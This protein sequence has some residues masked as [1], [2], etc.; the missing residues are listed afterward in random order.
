M[1]AISIGKNPPDEVN[2]VDRSGR[3]AASRS[4]TRWTRPPARSSS[5]ASSTRRCAIRELRLHPAY[6]VGR[7][8]SCATCSSPTPA[9]WCR[10]PIIAVRPIGVM[11]MEDEGGGD[12]KI[13]A[14]PVPKLTK[15]YENVHNYTDLPQDHARPDPALLRALQGSGARQMGEARRAGAMPPRRSRL[16]VEAIERAKKAKG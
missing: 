15:R 13:I 8:R 9:R 16:I 12:E 7:R 3:L 10:A 14:V 1:D 2:V 11:M 4:S 5:T 6:A